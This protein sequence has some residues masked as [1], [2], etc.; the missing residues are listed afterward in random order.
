MESSNE[1]FS[2]NYKNMNVTSLQLNNAIKAIYPDIEKKAAIDDE[3]LCEAKLWWELSACVLSSQVSYNLAIAMSDVIAT[4]KVLLSEECN[5]NALY[6]YLKDILSTPTCVDNKMLRHRFYDS[7]A[8]QLAK[9]K[10]IVAKQG[11]S[12]TE[13]LKNFEN[14]YIARE[15]LIKHMPGLGPKQASMFLRNSGISYELAILDR[16]VL[17][18]MALLGLYKEKNQFISSINKYLHYEKI[19]N[20]YA[21]KMDCKIG[22][23]DWAIWIVM[24]VVN[25]E[26][27]VV[28]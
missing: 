1:K 9:C 7:K 6:L 14:H 17:N 10:E 20:E 3:K 19:L 5:E 4:S 13:L 24:R 23:M 18:Y 8:K 21:T 25:T 27:E 11:T 15:W 22:L 2:R 26:K 12:F 16:H 28:T